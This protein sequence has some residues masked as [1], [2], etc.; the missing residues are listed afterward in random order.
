MSRLYDDT[1][2]I[3]MQ[4]AS[5]PPEY[6]ARQLELT[7]DYKILRRLVPRQPP[8]VPNGFGSKIGIIVDLET[9]GL[10][11]AKDEIIEV[12]MVKFHSSNSGQVTGVTGTFQAFNEPSIPI[13]AIIIELTGITDE[14]VAGHLCLPQIKPEHI[15]DGE[16]ANHGVSV[17]GLVVRNQSRTGKHQQ[18]N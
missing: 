9:T 7:G 5:A 11:I 16:R 3:P 15:D 4:N 12:A 10:D 6:L 18:K 8:P 17:S 14:M 1:G 2:I 13:P